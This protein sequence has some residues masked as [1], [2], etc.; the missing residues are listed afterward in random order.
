MEEL[1]ALL[2][3]FDFDLLI[4]F[5]LALAVALGHFSYRNVR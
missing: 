5:D 1:E 2:I 3:A 4:A